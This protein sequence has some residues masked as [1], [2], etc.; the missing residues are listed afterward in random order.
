MTRKKNNN[1]SYLKVGDQVKIIAGQHKGK[2][3]KIVVIDTKNLLAQI[4]SIEDKLRY[5]SK[6]EQEKLKASGNELGEK[7]AIPSFLHISNLMYWDSNL[8]KAT[9]LGFKIVA[10][11]KFRY[12]KKSGNVL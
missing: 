12:L 4:D 5:Y 2:I 8:G 1:H 11:K 10:H 9:R 6:Q 3:G 7:K